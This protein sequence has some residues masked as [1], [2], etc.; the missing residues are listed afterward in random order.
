VSPN[1]TREVDRRYAADSPP[2]AESVVA[3]LTP[4]RWLTTDD[5]SSD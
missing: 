1:P 4:E 5:G 2:T 3:R